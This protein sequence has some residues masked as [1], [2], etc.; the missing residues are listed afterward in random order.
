M[1]ATYADLAA[2]G[3]SL[4]L[5]THHVE[6]IV[7]AIDRVIMLCEGQVHADGPPDEIL[8]RETLSEL[9]AFDASLERTGT[10]YHLW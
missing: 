5:V 3:C 1:R 9:F 10:T 4:V 7:S 2:S 6:D 8:T